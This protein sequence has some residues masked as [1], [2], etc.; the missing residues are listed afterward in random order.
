MLSI[1]PG[2]DRKGR[3]SRA[4]GGRRFGAPFAVALTVNA[5]VVGVLFRELTRRYEWSDFW[6]TTPRVTE[7]VTY[8]EAPRPAAPAGPAQAGRSGGDGIPVGDRSTT[9]APRLR[10][11]TTI[12][13]GIPSVPSEG[14]TGT[15][16]GSGPVIGAGGPTEGVR[17]SFGD[18]RLW[19]RPDP[20]PG[21]RTPKERVDSV[22][23]DL[24]APVRDSILAA[25]TRAAG[26]RRPG[27]WTVKGP[28]GKW[29]M[30]QSAIRLGK[31]SVPNAVLA[32]LSENFQ[33]NLR[34][35]PTE[36]DYNRRLTQIR[37]EIE[38]HSQR[39]MNEDEFRT[40]VKALRQRKDRERAQRLAA[41]RALQAAEQTQ[42]Q[43]P[44]GIERP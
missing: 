7:R 40:A 10:A 21:P 3:P 25:N 38:L 35:N 24:L 15:G 8:A 29:G 5:L 18:G 42:L 33:R 22:V 34:G 26:E 4:P 39:E 11:P 20:L 9:A 37:S 36:M 28:G 16:G 17:P 1:T 14:A 19:S 13:D 23:A 43:D 31:I 2:T 32:L 30:D 27:D 41:Q 12:P 44:N 6:S